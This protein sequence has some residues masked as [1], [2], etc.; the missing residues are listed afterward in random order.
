M[1][2]AR[3]SAFARALGAQNFIARAVVGRRQLALNPIY[4]SAPSPLQEFSVV[5]TDRAVNHMSVPFKKAMVDISDT[6]K[7]VYHAKHA[8]IIPG[9]GTYAMEATARQFATGKKAVVIR[10]GYFSYRWTKIFEGCGIPTEHTVLKAQPQHEGA[11][12]HEQQYAPCPVGQVV[13][14]IL[15]EKP[16]VVF[17]P[18]VETSTGMLL[19]NDY[20]KSVSD[21]VHRVGGLFVLDCIASGTAWV[22]MVE[23]GVDTLISAPQKGWTGPSCAG[24]V[25]LSDRGADVVRNTSSSSFVLD[26]R[27]WLELMETY[28]AGGFMYHATMPTD[29]LMTFR[30]VMLETKAFGFDNAHAAA[31]DLGNRVHK[32]MCEDKGLI[33]IAAPGFQA[34][35]VVVVHTSDA[36]VAAKFGAAGTQIAAGVPFMIGEPPETKTFRIGLFGLDKL[37]NPQLTAD[38]LKTALDKVVPSDIPFIS[39]YIQKSAAAVN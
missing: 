27:K 7:E 39:G 16:A 30:D 21:A 35:G 34:P 32:M 23:L 26:L 14:T 28:E 9:S 3:N 31:W 37:K 8:V 33:R 29:A 22:D 10:N 1:L 18:H 2:T 36:G 12:A 4:N 11:K 25:M 13:D 20:I 24:L 17:A 6:L 15:K 5:Y 38:T 19:P